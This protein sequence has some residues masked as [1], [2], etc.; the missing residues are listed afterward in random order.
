MATCLA[1][2]RTPLPA[3]PL[4]VAARA[5]AAAETHSKEEVEIGRDAGALEAADE[6]AGP[7]ALPRSAGAS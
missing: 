7:T 1:E 3:L 2:R 6:V 4:R 5:A